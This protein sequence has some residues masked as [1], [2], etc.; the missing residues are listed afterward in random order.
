ML[1]TPP[2]ERWNTANSVLERA[3]AMKAVAAET[4]VTLLDLNAESWAH[5]EELGLEKSRNQ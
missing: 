1:I 3:E 4:G 2:T 5:F